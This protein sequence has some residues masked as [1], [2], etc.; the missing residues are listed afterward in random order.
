MSAMVYVLR[1]SAR[2]R[3]EHILEKNLE[4]ENKTTYYIKN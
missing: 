3:G 4:V 1:F 2:G